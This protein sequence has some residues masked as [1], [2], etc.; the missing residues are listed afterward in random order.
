MPLKQDRL[1]RTLKLAQQARALYEKELDE[2]KVEPDKRRRD[3]RWRGLDASCR[4]VESR[5]ESLAD[6]ISR[7]Q[8]PEE[9]TSE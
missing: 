7:G 3:P 9:A 5:L 2:K 6:L 8:A 4:K 1:E